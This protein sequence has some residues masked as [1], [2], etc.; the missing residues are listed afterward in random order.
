MIDIDHFKKINDSYSHATGDQVLVDFAQELR[1]KTRDI[2]II[3]RYG[4]EEFV[5]ILP[6]TPQKDAAELAE[7]LRHQIEEKIT[8]ATADEKMMITVSIG[9]ASL[10][11]EIHSLESL[12]DTADT[13]LYEA[14]RSGRNR[15]FSL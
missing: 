4:G 3:G 12:L 2:D 1:K 7:R 11:E 8:P 9:V 5:V 13:A 10:D 14:K 15:V 6:S